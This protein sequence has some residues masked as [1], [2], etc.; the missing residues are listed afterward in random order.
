MKLQCIPV[1]GNLAYVTQAKVAAG[2]AAVQYET[3]KWKYW[4]TS[5]DK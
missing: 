4:S 5:C 3:I 2:P 1:N